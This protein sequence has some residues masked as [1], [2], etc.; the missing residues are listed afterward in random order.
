MKSALS[1]VCDDS[2]TE[3]DVATLTKSLTLARLTRFT[4]LTH[5]DTLCTA[6]RF[7][8]VRLTSVEVCEVLLDEHILSAG[9]DTSEAACSVKVLT[10]L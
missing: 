10:S 9:N 1:K 4:E 2:N 6:G 3:E 5:V 7:E 8:V